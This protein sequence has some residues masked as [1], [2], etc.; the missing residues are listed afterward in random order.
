MDEDVTSTAVRR[1]ETE[2][3]FGIEEL[4]RARSHFTLEWANA[5]LEAAARANM[6]LV[7]SDREL[8]RT[9]SVGPD[10]IRPSVRLKESPGS[11][12][13]STFR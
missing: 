8:R 4:Y 13:I 3:F 11:A 5:R 10:K 7:G 6:A 2:T 9:Y 12:T 1:D